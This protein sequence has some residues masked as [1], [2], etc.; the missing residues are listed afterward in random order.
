MR[1]N[2]SKIKFRLKKEREWQANW[3]TRG[4]RSIRSNSQKMVCKRESQILHVTEKLLKLDKFQAFKVLASS[5]FPN[6]KHNTSEDSGGQDDII[7]IMFLFN[8]PSQRPCQEQ[9]PCMSNLGFCIE[10]SQIERNFGLQAFSS[11]EKTAPCRKLNDWRDIY[12]LDQK[13][14]YNAVYLNSINFQLVQ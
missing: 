12:S 3:S 7:R 5:P 11:Q 10:P 6:Y 9:K 2:L 4:S 1:L 13:P 8:Q 14:P